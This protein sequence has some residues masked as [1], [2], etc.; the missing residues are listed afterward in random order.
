MVTSGARRGAA[1]CPLSEGEGEQAEE[2]DAQATGDDAGE[3]EQDGSAHRPG[4]GHSEP[5]GQVLTPS[6]WFRSRAGRGAHLCPPRQGELG[7]AAAARQALPMALRVLG[8]AHPAGQG[9]QNPP[10]G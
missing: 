7:L 8:R 1:R 9:L 4:R 2:N 5:A 3:P 10:R 6:G